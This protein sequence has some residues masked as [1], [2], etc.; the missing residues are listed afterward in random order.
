[1]LRLTNRLQNRREGLFPVRQN[2][3][4]CMNIHPATSEVTNRVRK[5]QVI[6]WQLTDCKRPNWANR[7][8]EQFPF[9]MRTTIPA[10]TPWIPTEHQPDDD[11]ENR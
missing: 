9:I 2:V 3:T 11:S 1:M 5:L 8:L 10:P 4:C 6:R 7:L